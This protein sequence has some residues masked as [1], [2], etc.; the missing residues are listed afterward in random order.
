MRRLIVGMM[1]ACSAF[2]IHAAD[3][4]LIIG[5][6][7]LTLGMNKVAT[8]DQLKQYIVQCFD[9]E[10]NPPECNSWVISVKQ[11]ELYDLLGSVYFSKGDRIKTVMKYYNQEQW[12][13]SPE[14]FTET[15]FHRD[16]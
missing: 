5:G 7:R 8:Q 4:S 13:E 9:N 16:Q 15:G 2:N 12:R 1:L 6:A 11:G 14:K 10:K 3:E